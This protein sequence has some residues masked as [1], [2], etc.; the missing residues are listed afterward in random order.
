MESGLDWERLGYEQ[1]FNES[2]A[3]ENIDW[4][5]VAEHW[6]RI[7]EEAIEQLKQK[8]RIESKMTEEQIREFAQFIAKSTCCNADETI[9]EDDYIFIPC[10]EIMINRKTNTMKII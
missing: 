7:A 8:K 2:L 6:Q 4:K 10:V 5:Q 3:P 1:E 9:I